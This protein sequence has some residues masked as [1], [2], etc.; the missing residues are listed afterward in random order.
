MLLILLRD[1]GGDKVLLTRR[2]EMLREHAGEVAFPGGK[3]DREDSSMYRTALRECYEEVGIAEHQLL[4]FA[5]LEPH[6]T[7]KGANVVPFVA[8]LRGQP[9]LVLSASEIASTKWV[10]LDVFLYDRRS[11]THV[12]VNGETEYWAPV[13]DYEDYR[14]WGF[15]ARVLVSFVNRYYGR[16]IAR[17]HASAEEQT[18]NLA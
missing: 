8:E 18:L 14:I 15:T 5:E 1:G 9:K 3:R 7:S 16:Q 11:L 17:E 2:A 13:Y 4:Y 12:F 10:P 6:F